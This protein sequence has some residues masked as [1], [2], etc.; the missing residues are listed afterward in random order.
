MSPS[1]RSSNTRT[2]AFVKTPRPNRSNEEVGF[3]LRL[4][5]TAGDM[6]RVRLRRKN[7]LK[8]KTRARIAKA[9][10]PEEKA[11]LTETAAKARS[12]YLYPALMLALNT[13]MRDAEMKNL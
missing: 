4:M 5:D 10:T 13:G 7:L 3:L 11:R 12:P 2:R 6:L 8:L 1:K 9:F